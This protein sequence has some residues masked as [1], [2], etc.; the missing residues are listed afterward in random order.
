[1]YDWQTVTTVR[2]SDGRGNQHDAGGTR[3][4]TS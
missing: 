4:R 3:A 1:V 2:A